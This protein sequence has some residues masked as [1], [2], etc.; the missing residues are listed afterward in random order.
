MLRV[1]DAKADV[2]SGRIH[3]V[4]V[5]Q[6]RGYDRPVSEWS[7]RRTLRELVG[8]PGHRSVGL[9]SRRVPN[10]GDSNDGFAPVD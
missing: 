10:G 7:H 6:P 1:P 8:R 2:G 3:V 9:L 5:D 4:L